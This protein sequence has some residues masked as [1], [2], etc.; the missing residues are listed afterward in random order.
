MK[1]LNSSSCILIKRIGL[2]RFVLRFKVLHGRTYSWK[3]YFTVLLRKKFDKKS[4]PNFDM[5]KLGPECKHSLLKGTGH[6]K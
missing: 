6:P 3:K 4:L 5:S 2:S 1:L